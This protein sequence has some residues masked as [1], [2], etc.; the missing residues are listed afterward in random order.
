VLLVHGHTD[1]HLPD[2]L[3]RAG[4]SV[5]RAASASEALAALERFRPHVI[6]TDLGSA[7]EDAYALVA[8]VRSLPADDGG[9]IPAVALSARPQAEEMARA[10][11]AGFQR[12]LAMPV[13]P[14]ELAAVVAQLAQPP[15]DPRSLD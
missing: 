1:S 8:R 11:R 7:D 6:V 9:A 15:A 10:L 3:E 13:D 2:M 5:A 14:L 12:H 4:A